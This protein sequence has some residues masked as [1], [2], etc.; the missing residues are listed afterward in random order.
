MIDQKMIDRINELARKARETDLTEQEKNEQQVLRQKYIE[1]Y[2]ESLK[3][4][5]DSIVV[6]DEHGNKTKISPKKSNTPHS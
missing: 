5:L 2:R 3:V 4:Q 6:V 1:A